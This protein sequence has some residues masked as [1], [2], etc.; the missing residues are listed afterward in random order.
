MHDDGYDREDP[1]P[2]HNND[3]SK[4]KTGKRVKTAPTN[5][6]TA[7]S[8]AQTLL[9][10]AHT[11]LETVHSE[12]YSI[13][14]AMKNLRHALDSFQLLFDKQIHLCGD[15]EGFK[16]ARM[17]ADFM[18]LLDKI[19]T[20]SCTIENTSSRVQ[21]TLT[22]GKRNV[23]AHQT[24]L[25]RQRG[26][27][28][29]SLDFALERSWS[30]CSFASVETPMP[31]SNPMTLLETLF[32]NNE[33]ALPIE[34]I[35]AVVDK[36]AFRNKM[37][38]GKK[39]LLLFFRELINWNLVNNH[40]LSF[41]DRSSNKNHAIRYSSI[42]TAAAWDELESSGLINE[43]FIATSQLESFVVSTGFHVLVKTVSGKMNVQ[44]PATSPPK[45]PLSKELSAAEHTL[46]MAKLLNDLA[47]A[48]CEAKNGFKLSVRT[49]AVRSKEFSKAFLS[50]SKELLEKE[51]ALY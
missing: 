4:V 37:Q 32:P 23:Q 1:L 19:K 20:S 26:K 22:A 28:L 11:F 48:E 33:S 27:T 40:K 18:D 34:N 49:N 7:Q 17:K 13:D 24:S 30:E 14:A 2:V 25:H 41:L 16:V 45:S 46:S 44:V 9:V 5:T 42:L 10:Q 15:I 29:E 6:H 51:T 8:R 3:S 43:G 12:V 21:K 47:N 31:P 39:E 38:L 36:V 35:I 50:A